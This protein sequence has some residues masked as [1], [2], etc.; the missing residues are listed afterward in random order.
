MFAARMGARK[1][2][3]V[4][5]ADIVHKAREIISA[6]GFSSVIEIVHGRMEE[7]VLPV[8]KVDIII[9]EWMGYFLL[10]ESMLPSVLYARDKYLRSPPSASQSPKEATGVYPDKALMF[11]AGIQ[12]S[13]AHQTR[14]D[15]WSDVYGFN[16][17]CLVEERERYL[18]STVEI[19]R[20]EQV[21]TNV[22]QIKEIDCQYAKD[23]ELDFT[24]AFTLDVLSGSDPFTAFMV[25]FDTLFA[26]HCKTVINLSTAPHKDNAPGPEMTTHW[27]QSVFYLAKPLSVV[28]GDQIR[29]SLKAKRMASNPRAY[30]VVIEYALVHEGKEGVR[31]SQ[32][33]KVQ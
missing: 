17:S 8:D 16:M 14:V 20:P 22:V 13:K 6:N 10:F 32:A 3:G 26:M 4:D 11:I 30:D 23:A 5:A 27:Q 7:V 31:N 28:A 24:Q 12:T 21:V 18:S 2:I 1:V 29:G 15:W 9:S 33:Y 19:I 25:Y